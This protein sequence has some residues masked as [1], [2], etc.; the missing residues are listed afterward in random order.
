M[1]GLVGF[2]LGH[3]FSKEYFT[4]KFIDLGIEETYELFQIPDIEEID[5]VI[6]SYD[7]ELKGFNVTIP[8]KERIIDFLTDIN[9]DAN[10]IGAV[11]VVKVDHAEGIPSLIGFNTDWKGFLL[12]LTPIIEGRDIKN[13]L[14]LGT[15][16]AS[17][18][19]AFALKTLGI[20]FQFVSRN[21]DNGQYTYNDLSEAI[22]ANNR[23][24]INTTPLGTFPHIETYPDIP[25]FGISSE[26]ICY[27]LVYNPANTEFLKRAASRGAIVKNGL[28][29]L[30]LQADLAWEIWNE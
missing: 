28:E 19:V 25:Y 16:G 13:A 20:H 12:S 1:Y 14:I 23:L 29:M 6:S 24:I 17:K 18:A 5:N 15:G 2:P 9:S 10:A 7:S 26:H 30:R 8:Y 4:Q 21:K 11:N 3:S 22:I 27:D